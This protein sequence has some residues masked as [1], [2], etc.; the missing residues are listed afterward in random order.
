VLENITDEEDALY[1]LHLVH[2]QPDGALT[3]ARSIWFNR[4]NLHMARQIIFDP[5]GNILT[6][7]RY[8]GWQNYDG[9]PFPKQIEINRPQDE[10]A[11]VLNVVK[12]DINR[13]VSAEKFVLEQPEGTQLQVLGQPPPAAPPPAPAPPKG[14][15]KKKK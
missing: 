11:V 13:G 9:V 3:P 2:V 5:A 8:S 15:K 12:M 6:D 14:K 4:V 1:V 7:A 10:Y